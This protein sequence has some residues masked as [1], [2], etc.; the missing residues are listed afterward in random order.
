MSLISTEYWEYERMLAELPAGSQYELRHFNLIDMPAPKRI[1]Q[2][3]TGLVYRKLFNFC[4]QQALGEV[5]V[6]PFDVIFDKGNVCQPDVI[7]LSAPKAGLSTE[8]GIMGAPD[9]L[10]E[11]VSK[12]SVV[13]DYVEKKNDYETFGV[14]EYWLIDPLSETIIVNALVDGKYNV[15]SAVEESG[16]AS[17]SLLAGFTLTFA[18]VFGEPAPDA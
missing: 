8:A 5:F 16:T 11:V 2:R 4:E 10:V 14:A 9:L 17:S 13:R 1:H 6:S 7:F 3:I 15:F 12:G 18:E